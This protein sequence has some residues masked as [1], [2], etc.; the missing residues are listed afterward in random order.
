M[1]THQHANTV[2]ASSQANGKSQA[3]TKGQSGKLIPKV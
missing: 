3:Q 1:G 2:L